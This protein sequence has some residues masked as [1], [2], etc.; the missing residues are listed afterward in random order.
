MQLKMVGIVLCLTPL[1]VWAGSLSSPT[2]VPSAKTLPKGIKRASFI[3]VYTSAKS[4]FDGAGDPSGLGSSLHKKITFADIVEGEKTESDR[5]DAAALVTANGYQLNQVVGETNANVNT[6]VN[7]AVPNF[8]YGISSNW[9]VGIGVPVIRSS[10]SISF[11][12]RT[13]N[14]MQEAANKINVPGAGLRN[15]AEEVREKMV[16]AISNS[17]R[18]N[19]YQPLIGE[20][21]T[22][23]GDISLVSKL[24]VIQSDYYAVALENTVVLPTGKKAELNKL[25]DVAGGDGQFDVG[26]GVVGDYYA[27]DRFTL[28]GSINYLAQLPG[29]KDIRV[30]K[31][32][33]SLLSPE[34][35]T[36][37]DYDLGDTLKTQFG[38]TGNIY[39][40][41][42]AFGGYS[43][44]YKH[45][46]KYKGS[47]YEAYRYK[48]LEDGTFQRLHSF[49]VG[50]SYSTVEAY[51]SKSFPVPVDFVLNYSR[52]IAG[53]NA[54]KDAQ[55]SLNLNV[56]F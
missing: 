45:K 19:G 29:K 44:Q 38:V 18:D 39:G 22:Q 43:F 53:K 10:T 5:R 40:G 30:P 49:Q 11:G 50:A 25:G 33:G 13:N 27:T 15:K 46:D 55:T 51:R 1:M 42:S 2:G 48:F 6:I 9:T 26:V 47:Q 35:E 3:G 17:A 36:N 54:V 32:S 8:S 23:L 28:S 52:P 37:V 7:V 14:L 34:L 12:T 4:K 21:K 31:K 24:G 56:Y 16:N 41:L 20:E